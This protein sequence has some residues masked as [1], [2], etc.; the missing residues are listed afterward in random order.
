LKRCA[1]LSLD[2]DNQWSYL[3]T[4]GDAGWESFPSYLDIVVPRIL[5]TLAARDLKITFFLVGQDADLEKNHAAIASIAAA[6][7]EIGNHSFHHEPWL[8]LYSEEEVHAEFEQSEQAIEKVTGVR[9]TMFR[10]PGFSLSPT[11]L[12]V[13]KDRNYRFDAS[14]MPT[15]LGPLARAYYL[16]TSKLVGEER[17][18][19]AKLFGTWKTGL[20]PVKPYEWV[21]PSGHLLELPVS[22]FPWLKFPFHLSYVLYL[23]TYS[24]ALA[25]MYFRMALR[26]CRMSRFGPSLLLHPL[27]FLSSED[28]QGLDFFPGMKMPLNQKMQRV[29]RYLDLYKQ[30]FEVKPMGEYA[31]DLTHSEN[32]PLS[33]R[34]L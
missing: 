22:T 17:E 32:S 8:H 19:R 11:V 26:A 3:K 5:D 25:S 2:L 6:G 30:A 18:K 31:Y 9:T 13:L 16:R 14:T 24:S 29:G 20:Q 28:V 23:S 21:L 34:R 15:Y 4:H 7:H 12:R 33:K 10:G 1:G 27:D